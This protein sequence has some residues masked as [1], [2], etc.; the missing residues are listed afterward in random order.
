MASLADIQNQFM[1][2]LQNKPNE[3]IDIIAEQGQLSS[4]ERLSIYQ[5]AYK[6]R[7]TQV[8]EQDHE[9][10]GKYLGDE[11]FDLMVL[12]YLKAYPSTNNSLRE[13]SQNLPEFLKKTSPF[14]EHDIL[15]DI[16]QFERLLLQAFDASDDKVLSSAALESIAQ[17]DWPLLTLNLHASAHLVT[18]HTAAVESFQALKN[19]LAPPNAKVNT[20]R[21]WLIWRSPEKITEYKK[22]TEEE[23]NLLSLIHQKNNFSHLCQSLIGSH[24]PENIAVVLIQYINVWLS[25][26]LLKSFD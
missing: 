8:I 4:S 3:L 10:L 9:Q 15:S 14:K 19:D 26:G 18:F 12:G 2:L 13:F 21:F 6:I 24:P 5:S 25:Q 20:P 11:L 1:H 22:V 7:L 23:Y 16:A 17:N